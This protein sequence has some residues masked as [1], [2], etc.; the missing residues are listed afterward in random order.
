VAMMNEILGRAQRFQDLLTRK[1]G[2][3]G[4][5]PS[6]QLTPE[7]TPGYDMPVGVEDR[8]LASDV[9]CATA[10]NVAAVAAKYSVAQLTNPA[11]SNMVLVVEHITFGAPGAAC[12][13]VACLLQLP[14]LANLVGAGQAVRRDTRC[15][16]TGAYPARPA[17][18][19]TYD[20]SPPTIGVSNLSRRQLA[21]GGSATYDYPVILAP[22]WSLQVSQQTVNLSMDVEFAW[23]EVPLAQGEAGPF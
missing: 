5:A 18:Q 12:A 15:V 4:G 3:T 8:I 17:G 13:M 23:R 11:G 2:I 14:A 9:L 7:I 10:F 21:A 20:N 16:P 19:V 1:W 6:P 22:G